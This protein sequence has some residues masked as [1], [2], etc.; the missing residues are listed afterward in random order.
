ML[1]RA[2]IQLRVI[3]WV[4]AI[5]NPYN[6]IYDKMSKYLNSNGLKRYT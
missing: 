4:M 3:E 1:Q 2:M 6:F 5:N